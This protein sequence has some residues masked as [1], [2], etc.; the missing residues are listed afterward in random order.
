MT[1]LTWLACGGDPGSPSPPAPTEPPPTS[2]PPSTGLPPPTADSG[3]DTGGEGTTPT[4]TFPPVGSFEDPGPF[5]TWVDPSFAECTVHRPATLGAQGVR[6]PVVIW[7]NGTA[8]TPLVY[9]G[10]LE[11]LASHGFVVAAAD[12]PNAGDGSEMLTCLDAVLA[13]DL[14][15]ASEYFDRIDEAQVAAAGHSQGGAGALMAALDPRVVAS[16]PVQPYI[17]WI[18]LGGEFDQDAIGLQHAPMFLLSGGLDTLAIPS[19]HQDPIFAGASAP[20]TWATLS[21]ATHFEPVGDGGEFRGPL[22]AFLRA[23]LMGDLTAA[24][25]VD[26]PACTLCDAPGWDVVGR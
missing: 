9:F 25:V 7:G 20:V 16:A 8:T 4:G 21:N 18:P 3:G 6:H 23:R 22:T 13:A 17:L 11:H 14:D 5:D 10:L 15:P 12:T 2:S 1:I 19:I 26:A 24:E